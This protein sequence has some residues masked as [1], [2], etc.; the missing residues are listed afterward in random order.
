MKILVINSGSSSI[1]YQLFNMPQEEVIAKGLLERI[2]EEKS[3]FIQKSAKG[4]LE[5]EGSIATHEQGINFIID[6]LTDKEKGVIS[7]I[8]EIQ[9]VGHRVVHGEEEF[10]ESVLINEKVI[11]RIEEYADLAP[12]HNPPNLM[13]IMASKKFLPNAIQ[14][15][16]F[17]TAFHHAIPPKAYIYGIPYELYEKYKIRRYGFH[18]TSHLYVKRRLVSILK[19]PKEELN[20]ITC[21]LGNGCSVSA[22]AHGKSVDTSMGFTPL[23]GLVMGTRSGDIDPA[24]IFYLNGKGYTPEDLNKLLNKKS[25]LMGISGISNDMR[26]LFW[27]QEKGNERAKLAIEVF[28]YRLRKYIGAYLAVL[29]KTDAIIFTG[30]IGENNPQIR[31]DTLS[32]MESLGIEIEEEKNVSTVKGVEA[33]ISK[34]SSRVK[35]YVIPT[36]EELCIA[37]DAYELTKVQPGV[38][39][40]KID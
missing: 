33:Q 8:E 2:G 29:G 24:I 14:V 18:G 7:S 12:L 9:G 32:G 20:L 3:F 5:L 27:A 11:M 13:G 15:A 16:C 6:M 23:E 39:S 35:V 38:I 28:C 30:G 4:K 31:Q 22:I 36:N 34:D 25:G 37:Q 21:H 10:T 26:N 1:K 40:L 17:D 19:M